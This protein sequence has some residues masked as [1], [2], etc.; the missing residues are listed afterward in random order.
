MKRGIGPER[1]SLSAERAAE[2]EEIALWQLGTRGAEQRF[3]G[4]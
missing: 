1:Q 3:V 2:P 4:G